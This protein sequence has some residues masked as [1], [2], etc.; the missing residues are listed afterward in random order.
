MIDDAVA[1]RVTTLNA[2]NICCLAALW[3][4][5]DLLSACVKRGIG[6]LYIFSGCCLRSLARIWMEYLVNILW[7]VG[8]LPI[9]W[10]LS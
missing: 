1:A 9:G 7:S 5:V 4:L 3:K 10:V 2:C 6:S 8:A